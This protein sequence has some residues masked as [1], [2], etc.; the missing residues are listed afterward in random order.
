MKI[1]YGI[2]AIIV[3]YILVIPIAWILKGITAIYAK[4][5]KLADIKI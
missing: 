4:L 5:E 1:F 3:L 2:I